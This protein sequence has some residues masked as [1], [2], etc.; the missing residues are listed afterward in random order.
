METLGTVGHPRYLGAWTKVAAIEATGPRTVRV[1]FN[2]I[3]REMPLIIGLRP[4]IKKA[5]YDGMDFAEASEVAPVG[6]GHFMIE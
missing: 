6:S 3:D 1:T 5:T 4:I 2:T